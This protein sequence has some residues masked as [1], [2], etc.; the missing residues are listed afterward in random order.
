MFQNARSPGKRYTKSVKLVQKTLFFR[1]RGAPKFE[2]L[3]FIIVYNFDDF[4]EPQKTPPPFAGFGPRR[5]GGFSVRISPD[6][7][8][9]LI[10]TPGVFSKFTS[11][12]SKS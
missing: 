12:S 4:D 6:V 2:F 3:R 7:Q 11:L 5:R 10:R 1:A 9:E 8:S